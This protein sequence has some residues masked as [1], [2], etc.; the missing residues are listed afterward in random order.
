MKR[1][2]ILLILFVV[3]AGVSG[4]EV[5]TISGRVVTA[6]GPLPHAH[7]TLKISFEEK[8]VEVQKTVTREDGTYLFRN[9]LDAVYL[10]ELRH[11]DRTFSKLAK[12]GDALDFHLTGAV[13][14][15]VRYPDGT[16][17][18]ETLV[19]MATKYGPVAEAKTDGNGRYTFEGLMTGTTYWVGLNVGGVP[20]GREVKVGDE[21]VQA[22][23]TIYEATSSDEGIKVAMDHVQIIPQEGLLDVTE[24]IVFENAGDKVFDGGMLR[25][26]LP[27]ERRLTTSSIMQ[28]CFL[29][30]EDS[31]MLDPM[32]PIMPG[33]QFRA[34]V[35]YKLEIDSKE[36]S[37]AKGLAYNTRIAVLLVKREGDIDA[38]AVE[39]IGD[40]KTVEFKGENF[41]GFSAENLDP[42]KGY[43]VK[44]SG[45]QPIDIKTKE[46]R[47]M[48]ALIPL[49]AILASIG[50][51]LAR[52][53]TNAR[54][55]T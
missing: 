17:V 44:I 13:K 24:F 14:G 10:V 40:R 22:D 41:Y 20:Y 31:A 30:Y 19:Q 35:N 8:F 18:P 49:P 52:R 2:T 16:P 46:N 25:V 39:G 3:M 28:C 23:L 29:Q 12:P 33:G 53:K 9:L 55:K 38:E 48:I 26:A 21:P 45:L 51:L 5:E 1:F 27:K 32:Q 34:W 36:Y 43:V 50:Y 11:K 4:E 7:M 47:G 6:D 42:E 37:F 15:A 54:S